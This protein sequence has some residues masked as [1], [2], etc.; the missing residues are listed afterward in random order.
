VRKKRAD[1]RSLTESRCL[2]KEG[3]MSLVDGSDVVRLLLEMEVLSRDDVQ[4]IQAAQSDVLLK[5]LLDKRVIRPSEAENARLALEEFMSS[6]N[7]TRRTQAQT[8]LYNLIAQ[9]LDH[10][11]DNACVQLRKQK[12]RITSRT[13]PAVA[14]AAKTEG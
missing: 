3:D 13:W 10:R 4:D 12:E 2:I 14:V 5:V 7:Q 1:V 9:G 8:R 11:I 6:A